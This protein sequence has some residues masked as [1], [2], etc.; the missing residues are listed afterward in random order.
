MIMFGCHCLKTHYGDVKWRHGVSNFRSIESLFKTVFGMTT[1]KHQRSL[2]RFLCERNPPVTGESPTPLQ[3]DSNAENISIWFWWCHNVSQY[4]REDDIL[5]VSCE[6]R[7][8]FMFT[9]N[10]AIS[11]S[12]ELCYTIR[13]RYNTV[14]NNGIL[15]IALQWRR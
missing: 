10:C 9:M 14:H 11:L 8:W 12:I 15:L 13:S 5:G 2:L 4:S 3:R 7:F 1:E 6:S